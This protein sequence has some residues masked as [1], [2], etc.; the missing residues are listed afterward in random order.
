LAQGDLYYV[1]QRPRLAVVVRH[2]AHP[3]QSVSAW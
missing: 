2:R 1:F 3:L